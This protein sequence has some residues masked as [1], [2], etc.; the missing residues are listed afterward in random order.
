[1]LAERIPGARLHIVEGAGHGY[2]AQDPVG[3]HQ[4]VTDFLRAHGEERR[5]AASRWSVA[6]L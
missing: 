2:P 6:P 3:V 1:M 5:R 4:L